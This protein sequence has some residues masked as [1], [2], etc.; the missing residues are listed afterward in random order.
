MLLK[1]VYCFAHGTAER[2]FRAMRMVHPQRTFVFSLASF[3]RTG[4]FFGQVIARYLLGM[5]ADTKAV[6]I[7]TFI[8][9]HLNKIKINKKK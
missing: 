9:S 5:T 6:G 4:G 8:G 7:P 3:E 1:I 2:K